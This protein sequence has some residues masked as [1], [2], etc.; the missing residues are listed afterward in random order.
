MLTSYIMWRANAIG[1]K[2]VLL[3]CIDCDLFCITDSF[4]YFPN[5]SRQKSK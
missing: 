5:R 3:Q 4:K 1:G 2:W